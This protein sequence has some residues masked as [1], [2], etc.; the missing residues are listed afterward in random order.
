M[1]GEFRVSLKSFLSFF[2]FFF[3]FS[4]ILFPPLAI[5]KFFFLA[6]MTFMLAFFCNRERMSVVVNPYL[7]IL[8]FFIGLLTS[9][10][11]NVTFDSELSSQLIFTLLTLLLIPVCVH[12]KVNF[13]HIVDT[14]GVI[15]SFFMLYMSLDY[16][17]ILP[18]DLPFAKK[19][20]AFFLDYELGFVGER[21][22]GAFSL[23]MMHFRSAPVLLVVISLICYRLFRAY[24]S[25]DVFKFFL[26]L[27]AITFS[28]SRAI[29]LFSLLSILM[30]FFMTFTLRVRLFLA[31]VS[32]PFLVFYLFNSEFLLA[33]LD[34]KETSN[35]IK[36]QH[37]SSFFFIADY[38]HFL[39]GD[40]LGA[41]YYTTGF[42]RF[43]SQTEVTILD[44]IRYFGFVGT[45]LLYSFLLFPIY[46]RK[47]CFKILSTFKGDNFFYASTF[48]LYV[49][50]SWT[51]P[52]LFNSFGMVIVLW[53][54]SNVLQS[55]IK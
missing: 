31:A 38:Q 23:S 52:I 42:N 43:A 32:I 19:L 16:F 49:L 27:G 50:M 39:L 2:I 1:I 17:S 28:G 33:L 41:F 53:Y 12:F 36:S 6:L 4:S 54:W 15:L 25:L 55:E 35:S 21:E 20:V 8:I 7:I 18:F 44:N 13:D 26:V 46:I 22:F 3:V 29:L 37:I 30:V 14:V 45:M 10:F 48:L 47:G 24:S 9:F 40:G 51:N 11:N 34:A 5:K